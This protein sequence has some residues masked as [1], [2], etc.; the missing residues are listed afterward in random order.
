MTALF[1]SRAAP[2]AAR[3]TS[4]SSEPLITFPAL[5]PYSPARPF[6]SNSPSTFS[7]D[8]PRGGCHCREMLRALSFQP[9]QLPASPSWGRSGKMG[10]G[11]GFLSPTH[12]P[13]QPGTKNW[14]SHHPCPFPQRKP[15][16]SPPASV[17]FA[18]L[19]LPE[20]SVTENHS[21]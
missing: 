10:Q 17:S 18:P 14:P 13:G 5:K 9:S 3:L 21:G 8:P 7:L 4:A 20:I 12:L 2:G 6:L 19:R 1:L 11:Y 15:N 16:L